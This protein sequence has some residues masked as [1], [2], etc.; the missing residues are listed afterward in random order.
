MV[1]YFGYAPWNNEVMQRKIQIASKLNPEDV[2]RGWGLQHLKKIEEL[3]R[4]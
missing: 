4:D 3:H 1:F 2:H